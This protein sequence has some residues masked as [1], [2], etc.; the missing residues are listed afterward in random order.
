MSTVKREAADPEVGFDSHGLC[1]LYKRNNNFGRYWL[2]AGI[3]I[4]WQ[5]YE[6]G[7]PVPLVA[8]LVPVYEELM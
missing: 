6:R 3:C 2:A 1:I 5:G 8:N 4:L 7:M